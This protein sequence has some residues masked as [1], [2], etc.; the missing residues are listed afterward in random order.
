[1][2]VADDM[3]PYRASA[4]NSIRLMFSP[5]GLLLPSVVR[6]VVSDMANRN[7]YDLDVK[8]VSEWLQWANENTP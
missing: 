5:G 3:S 4:P 2:I 7:D 8:L 1:M 6:N